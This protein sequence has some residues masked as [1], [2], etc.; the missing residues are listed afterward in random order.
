MLLVTVPLNASIAAGPLVPCV[1]VASHQTLVPNYSSI[2][3]HGGRRRLPAPLRLPLA[4]FNASI[5][6][7]TRT[8]MKIP[9]AIRRFIL[10][11]LEESVGI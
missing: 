7:K 5:K 9:A 4:N 1:L 2:T 3:A 10:V 8:N 11:H 6:F